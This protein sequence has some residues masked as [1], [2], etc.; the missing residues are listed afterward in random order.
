MQILIVSATSFE[1]KL[2]QDT[3]PKKINFLITGIGIP[4]SI[5]KLTNEL[6]RKNYDLVI[7]LGIAGSFNKEFELGKVVL[8]K[9]NYFA[10]I[11]FETDK[12]FIPINDSKIAPNQINRFVN[13]TSFSFL[14]NIQAVKEITVNNTSGNLKTISLRK[15]LFTAETES[16]EGAAIFY[17]CSEKQ[18]D[19]VEIRSISN[20]IEE[21]NTANWD[22]PLAISNLNKYAISFISDLLKKQH[23]EQD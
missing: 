11:G 6:S 19:F 23:N 7:N 12:G 2:L 22:I 13:K 9:E 15:E 10:D 1:I 5:F 17:V 8:I 14:E 20:Y 16:M 4:Q 18:I 3:F 21:R